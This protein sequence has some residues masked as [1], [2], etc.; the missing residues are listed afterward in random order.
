MRIILPLLV[1]IAVIVLLAI[2]G[3]SS[4]HQ[5]ILIQSTPEKVWNTLI[6]T[7]DYS[8]NPVMQLQRG[9]L[10]EGQKVTYLFTQDEETSYEINTK[11]I[12]ITKDSLLHQRG[13]V[14]M[15]ITFN[16]KYILQKVDSGTLLIIHED[17]SGIY[18]HFWNTASVNDAYARLGNA[19]KKQVES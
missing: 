4:V 19:I 11:V 13:G 10:E 18:T 14:P 12:E 1:L 9:E 8:W 5:E 6:N 17:Y 7:G 2:T 3:K 15:I 16:H